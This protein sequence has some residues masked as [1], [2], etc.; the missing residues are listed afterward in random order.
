MEYEKYESKACN[1]LTKFQDEFRA[2]Y[3]IDSY[4]NW[5]YKQ[6]S[7]TLRLYS[8]DNKELYFKYIPVGTFSLITNTWMWGWANEDSVEPRKF[9]TLKIKE[10]GKKK[11]YEKLIN[12]HVDGNEYTGWHL[13]SIAFQLLGGIG[14]YRVVSEHLEKYFLITDQITK[15]DADKIESEL[16]ECSTH[17]KLR[18]AY[19][20]QHLN[21]EFATGFEESFDTYRG[22]E[23]AE[24]D[25][26][27]AWCPLCEK[28]RAKTNGWND[29]SMEFAQIELVCEKCYFDIK[30]LN[31]AE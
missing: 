3:D 2:K 11:K 9:R 18:V 1:D 28:E 30:E 24:G 22:M 4:D 5:S 8:E 20:C 21:E 6:S 26:F 13:T 29:A 14:T 7:E 23:L 27:Q 15:E 19:I 25:D 17:G 16:I 31:F 10:F 12:G